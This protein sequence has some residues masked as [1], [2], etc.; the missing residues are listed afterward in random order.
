M[1][2]SRPFAPLLLSLAILVAGCA[3]GAPTASTATAGLQADFEALAKAGVPRELR[4][5]STD[6]GPIVAGLLPV[7]GSDKEEAPTS[8]EE[9]DLLG[10]GIMA[11]K[12]GNLPAKADLRSLFSPVRSQGAMGSCTAFAATALMEA[13][14]PK[15]DDRLSPLFF[16]YAERKDM[17]ANG[18][19]RATRKDTGAN[20]PLA[21]A[22]AIKIGTVTEKEVPYAD[23]KEGLAYDATEAHFAAAK[24]NRMKKKVSI[25][26]VMG[27]KSSL[28]A[29]KPFIM[30]IILYNSFMTR[31][32]ARTGEMFMPQRGETIMG[33]HA[34]TCV[35]YDDEKQAF[36][37][38][39]SWGNDWGQGGYFWMPYDFFKPTYI[40]ASR[41]YG[42]CWTLE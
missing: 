13:M 7:T 30:A 23:G 38:R 20:M 11:K 33:G 19:A 8:E 24:A 16:Y 1:F 12:Q 36:L 27:M 4:V 32:V 15:K 5:L 22:T 39:N 34:V 17:E 41:F 21:A 25:K 9:T 29:K 40:G 35:G 31:T 28:H 6:I 18:Q 3:T 26:T 37:V 42:S 2:A 14:S 10:I